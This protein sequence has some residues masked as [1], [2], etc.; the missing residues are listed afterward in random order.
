MSKFFS[1][2]QKM[3]EKV[4]C[5]FSNLTLSISLKFLIFFWQENV[6]IYSET[7]RIQREIPGI[8]DTIDDDRSSAPDKKRF[9]I[10]CL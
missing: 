5:A 7:G 2:C 6:K 9:V 4:R 3:S 1:K 10:S 8:C